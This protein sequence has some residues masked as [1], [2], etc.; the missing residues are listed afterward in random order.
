MIGEYAPML[1]LPDTTGEKWEDANWINSYKINAEYTI[2]YFWDPNCGHCKK[3]T[4]KLQVLYDKKFKERG[5]EI[6]SIGKATG[7]DYEAW[8]KY[9]NDNKLTFINVGLTKDVYN[10]AMEDPRPLLKH[11]TIQSLNYTDTYDIYSTPRIFVLD[12]VKKIV[13]KQLSIGQLE[14]IMDKLTGHEEDVKLYP[15]EDPDLEEEKMKK[16]A[17][18]MKGMK[19]T[20]IKKNTVSNVDTVFFFI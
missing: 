14:E 3:T 8:K 17:M 20:T 15:K 18:I 16:I 10:Q 7:E 4:P 12:K 19:D 13:F 6:Y 2:L 9:I 1:I 11:T 5:I